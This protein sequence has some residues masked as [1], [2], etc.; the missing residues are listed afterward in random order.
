M[1]VASRIAAEQRGVAGRRQLR[2]AGLADDMIDRL[3][4]SRVLHPLHRGVFAVGH[5]ELPPLG[6]ETAALLACGP[7]AVLSHRTAA[8]LWRLIDERP[9]AVDVTIPSGNR[10]HP[11]LTVHRT[12]VLD[13]K[14]IRIRD[15]LP[16]TDPE[17][18]LLDLAAVT[19]QRELGVAFDRARGKRLLRER[20]LQAM[21]E[22]A[23][24]RRGATALRTLLD[25]QGFSRS[26]AERRLRELVGRA[27]LPPPQCNVRV[28]A[29][30]VDFLWETERL[31]VEVDGYAYHG[32][33]EAFER[34]RRRDADLTAAGYRVVR[35][36]WRQLVE[37]PEAVAVR[38]A[39]AL[40]SAQIHG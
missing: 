31:I 37:E 5:A 4:A 24:R 1:R 18:T 22:R 38:L 26:E 11:K 35:I 10:R 29:Y 19:S 6:A 7:G 16:V 33:R 39:Q 2:G 27:R 3:I 9:G 30:E 20:R 36:T 15:G 12:K 34:D 17:R 28:A 8:F 23:P 32:D 40:W 13:R 25:V 21:V 14:A